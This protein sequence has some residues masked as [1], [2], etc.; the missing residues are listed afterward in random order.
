MTLN[1]NLG[2]HQCGHSL[3]ASRC[4]A[5]RS[6]RLLRRRGLE[7]VAVCGVIVRFILWLVGRSAMLS[8]I[9]VSFHQHL[10]MFYF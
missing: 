5:L 10:L 6:Q 7:S 9:E 1:N 4:T 3:H 8:S 2:T